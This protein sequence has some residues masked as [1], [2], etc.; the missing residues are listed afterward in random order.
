MAKLADLERLQDGW[1]GPGSKAIPAAVID[2]YVNLVEAFGSPVP[3]DLEPSAGSDGSISLGWNWNEEFYFEAELTPDGGL[4]L[5]AFGAREADDE[6]RTY[7]VFDAAVLRR[8][9]QTGRIER[10]RF[11]ALAARLTTWR[12]RITKN[13][14]RFRTEPR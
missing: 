8:F 7:P 9:Y 13:T 1:D 2:A 3:A 10:H 14:N 6:Q 11:P 5:C 4:Y 12:A